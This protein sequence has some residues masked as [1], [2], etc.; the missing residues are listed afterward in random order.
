M[1]SWARHR[2]IS[3]PEYPVGYHYLRCTDYGLNLQSNQLERFGATQWWTSNGT[4]P[5]WTRWDVIDDVAGKSRIKEGVWRGKYPSSPVQHWSARIELATPKTGWR[6]YYRWF[7][8]EKPVAHGFDPNQ[9]AN[10]LAAYDESLVKSLATEAFYDL[11]EQVPEEVNLSNFFLELDD[12]AKMLPKLSNSISKTLADGAL[13]FSFGSAPFFGDL[14]KLAD[15]ATTVQ[16]RLH[17]LRST[18]GKHVPIGVQRNGVLHHSPG[19][20]DGQWSGRYT[21]YYLTAI[22]IN[23]ESTFRAGGTLYH[24]LQGLNGI[25]GMIRGLMGALGFVNPLS[26]VWNAIPFSFILDWISDFS[27]QLRALSLRPFNGA[28]EV[29]NFTYSVKDRVEYKVLMNAE[30]DDGSYT[31]P[32]GKLQISRYNRGVGL[33]VVAAT[34]ILPPSAKQFALL[35]ALGRS[36]AGL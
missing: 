22:P 2:E 21:D 24:E 17:W 5:L 28:W 12:A 20:V 3:V 32:I 14:A 34:L 31:D 27:S 4:L 9:F 10:S 18:Y 15:I 25:E 16:A 6:S 8:A 29:H 7:L 23:T 26:T 19:N 13:S 35:T 33:P 11:S 36:R 1:A 30:F